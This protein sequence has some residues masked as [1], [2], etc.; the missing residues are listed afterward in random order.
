MWKH[1]IQ[2]NHFLVLYHSDLHNFFSFNFNRICHSLY[3]I[4]FYICCFSCHQQFSDIGWEKP[5][6]LVSDVSIKISSLCGSVGA[7]RARE[8]LFPCV[9]S[10]VPTQH[11]S[12]VSPVATIRIPAH[13]LAGTSL[14]WSAPPTA[15]WVTSPDNASWRRS[16]S[17]GWCLSERNSQVLGLPTYPCLSCYIT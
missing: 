9:N 6:M 1:C 3:Q 17:E 7:V 14:G 4:I 8:W 2:V 16:T 11:W 10:H 12:F 5:M 15:A 13:P